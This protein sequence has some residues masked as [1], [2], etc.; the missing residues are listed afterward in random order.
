MDVYNKLLTPCIDCL[1]A[2]HTEHRASSAI[3]AHTH[4]PHEAQ[5]FPPPPSEALLTWHTRWTRP[6]FCA[7]VIE[8][9]QT[10][11]KGIFSFFNYYSI[12]FSIA[13]HTATKLV[14]CAFVQWPCV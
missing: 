5:E 1:L 6:A 7:T 12:V 3:Y 9:N 14:H 13:I 4:G 2:L 8:N 11:G 10:K